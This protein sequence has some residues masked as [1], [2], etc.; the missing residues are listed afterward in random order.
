MYTVKKIIVIK[1][2]LEDSGV[3]SINLSGLEKNEVF[4]NRGRTQ[5]QSK[6]NYRSYKICKKK[7]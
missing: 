3:N 7:E 6:I 2:T 1:L 4:H 5:V